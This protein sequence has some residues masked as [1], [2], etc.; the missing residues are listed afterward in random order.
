MPW[1]ARTLSEDLVFT[2]SV[3]VSTLPP[4]DFVHNRLFCRIESL[5]AIV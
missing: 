1:Q 4:S 5:Y 3:T 2:G